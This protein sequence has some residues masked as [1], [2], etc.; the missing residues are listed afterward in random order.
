MNA[1]QYAHGY[2]WLLTHHTDAIRAIRH[3]HHLQHLIMPTIQSNTPHR[4]WL[5]R[6]RTLNTACEQHITQL[7]ALQTT[8]QVRARWS[9]AAHDAVH[10]ITHEINQLDQCRTPLATLLDR[11]TIERTA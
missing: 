6:L 2:A 9:P 7:R 4:Q 5:H 3:A 1:G 10:V 8:L 11:H